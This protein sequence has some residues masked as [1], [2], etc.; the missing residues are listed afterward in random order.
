MQIATKY[1]II[2]SMNYK[3]LENIQPV[4]DDFVNKKE[5]AGLNLLLC[6]D[7]REIGYWQ[8]GLADLEKNQPYQRDTIARLYSMSKPVTAVAAMIL[9]E[10]GK[11]DFAAELF[12]YL[13]EFKDVKVCTDRGRKG[14]PRPATRP[15]LIQD[16]L[17]MTSG[18][19]YGAWGEASFYGEHLTSEL[20][21]DLNEDE[22]DG[23]KNQITTREFARRIS[24]IP[25]NFEPGTEYNYGYSADI[26]GAV[27][28]EVSGMKFSQFLSNR[29]FKPLGMDDTAF[30]V[31]DSKQNRLAKVYRSVEDWSDGSEKRQLELFTNC[32]LG[33]QDKM[34]HEPAFESGG[35]GLC[36]TVDD[37]MKFALMLTNG[38]QLNGRRILS[39]NTVRRFSDSRLMPSVQ[40]TFDIK[41]P[42]LAGYSYCNLMRVAANPGA[43]N[44]F[45]SKGE[46]GWDGWL[47]PYMSVDRETGITIVMTM[48]RCDS[49]TTSAARK[50]RN[51]IYS[52]LN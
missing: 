48:Q 14:N 23:G 13:P 42:H 32:N 1:V 2:E 46:F 15:I 18:Y 7:G 17:N 43:C 44:V 33:I 6:K 28:E 12:R 39:E 19:G 26:L 20:I 45:T 8:S 50:A 5:A 27:I 3:L 30:Y 25:L 47:G 52:T 16:L 40:Q 49:G 29:I 31:P 41:M 21:N 37:Y 38:G 35:A 24:S 36:S 4:L 11:L 51:I 22:K 34:N 10:E 9:M